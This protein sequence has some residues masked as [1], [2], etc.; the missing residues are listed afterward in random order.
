MKPWICLM[1][2]SCSIKQWQ[3]RPKLFTMHVIDWY[4]P[5][6]IH[7]ALILHSIRLPVAIVVNFDLIKCS[8]KV[9][10]SVKSLIWTFCNMIGHRLR[11]LLTMA[12]DNYISLGPN[13]QSLFKWL[14]NQ[15]N[16]PCFCLALEQAIFGC[17]IICVAFSVASVKLFYCVFFFL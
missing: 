5:L 16:R 17:Q 6:S 11:T 15:W 3:Q 12:W 4:G 8:F 14:D 9:F 13:V 10:L 7:F 2:Y 1:N